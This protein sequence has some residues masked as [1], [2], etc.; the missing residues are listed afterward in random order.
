[1][2]RQSSHSP[3]VKQPA[4]R[5]T[6]E[7]FRRLF[8]QAERE[9]LRYVMALVPNVNDARDVVQETAVAL[10]EA[11]DKYDPARPFTPWACRFGLNQARLFLRS[12]GRRRRRVDAEVAELLQAR[13]IEIAPQLDAR[14]QYLGDCLENLPAEQRQL[15]RD[16]YFHGDAIEL[17]AA[18]LGRST[19]A[20][21]KSLQRIRQALQRCIERKQH[22]E[23]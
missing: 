5:M 14:R 21:Y 1:M 10:W 18:R 11:I 17:V 22:R 6:H 9:L 7:Q 19:D 3:A 23:D 20:A 8:V 13:R 12:E 16:Y 4:P 2:D 15:V